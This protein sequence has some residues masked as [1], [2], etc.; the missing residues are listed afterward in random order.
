DILESA[1]MKELKGPD[2]RPFLSS[3]SNEIHIV[4]ALYLDWF[5]SEG[6]YIG[7]AHN[8]TGGLYMV[9]L[10]LPW[11]I[12]YRKENMFPIFIPG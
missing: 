11:Y 7:G 1:A 3:T 10:N 8:G 2:G 9:V 5:N 12:R 6:N 4:L